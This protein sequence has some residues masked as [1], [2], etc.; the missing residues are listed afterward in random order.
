MTVLFFKVFLPSSKEQKEDTVVCIV[1]SMTDVENQPA[2]GF[3]P[4]LQLDCL[5]RNDIWWSSTVVNTSREKVL[6]RYKILV[7]F[8]LHYHYGCFRF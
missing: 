3:F 4:G 6:I 1:E 7:I 5:D 2:D 8:C